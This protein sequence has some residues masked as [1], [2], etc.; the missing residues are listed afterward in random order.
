MGRFPLQFT[1]PAVDRATCS[2][3]MIQSVTLSGHG[4]LSRIK[5]EQSATEMTLRDDHVEVVVHYCG[6]SFTDNYLRLGIIRN[7]KFPVVMGSEC[8]GY[9]TRVGG[10]VK[11]LKGGEKVLCLK[12]QGG[13][14]SRIVHV[15]RK[16][17][18]RLPEDLP[19]TDAV[20]LGLNFVVAHLCLFEI[21]H[22]KPK[23]R[24]FMQ[25]I[26]GGVGTALV[27]LCRTVPDVEVFGTASEMKHDDLMTLGVKC[28]Y[29]PEENYVERMLQFYPEGVDI[30][31]NSNGGKDT[32]KCC[33]LLKPCGTLINIG[34]NSTAC[35]P[36]STAWGFAKPSWDTKRIRTVELIS[37]NY[38]VAGLNV[39]T[40]LENH[41]KKVQ[42]I[43]AKVFE[44]HQRGLIRPCVHSVIPFDRVNDGIKEL[45]ERRNYGKIVLD[46]EHFSAHSAKKLRQGS[47][48][49]RGTSHWGRLS[50]EDDDTEAEEMVLDPE[51]EDFSEDMPLL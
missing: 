14:F 9:V 7:E 18:F 2:T 28:V 41:P 35:Y 34:S 51:D 13:L 30:M 50:D 45:C 40:W 42:T 29:C 19:L 20:A 23:D 47:K 38:R 33:K 31:V 36:R 4:D 22:L 39:G 25:S 3:R 6:L 43:L 46:Q 17:C 8:S 32:E 15:P 21:G 26:A 12:M 1:A 10:D 16:H 48:P 24:V 5:V 37:H 44:L 27:Q 11:D 49:Q